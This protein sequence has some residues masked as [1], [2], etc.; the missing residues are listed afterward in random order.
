MQTNTKKGTIMSD[1]DGVST[2]KNQGY[3]KEG[4]GDPN[5]GKPLSDQD[6][7]PVMIDAKPNGV[8]EDWHPNVNKKDRDTSIDDRSSVKTQGYV[9]GDRKGPDVGDSNKGAN[10]GNTQTAANQ[11]FHSMGCKSNAIAEALLNSADPVVFQASAS[12]LVDPKN[13]NK[14]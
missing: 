7:I 6:V 4:K 10:S 5:M 1:T 2:V 12:P 13:R 14:A 11:Q 3:V 9:K 8:G